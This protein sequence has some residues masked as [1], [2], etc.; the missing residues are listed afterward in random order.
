MVQYSH[1]ASPYLYGLHGNVECVMDS[2]HIVVYG[3][4]VAGE[5]HIQQLV[6][7]HKAA[8]HLQG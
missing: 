4:I 8:Q 7:G 2:I 3:H 5:Q 1:P 6:I